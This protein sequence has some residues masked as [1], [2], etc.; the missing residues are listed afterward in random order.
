MASLNQVNLMGNLGKDPETREV[1][2][3]TVTNFSLACHEVWKDKSG[4]KQEHTEWLNVVAW[5]PMGQNCAKYLKKGSAALVIGKIRTE[6]YEKDGEK[7][8][9][10]KIIASDVKFLSAAGGGTKATKEDSSDIPF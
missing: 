9:V 5:G 3:T 10:T 2:S 6:S 1:G 7:K 8:F 4:Q